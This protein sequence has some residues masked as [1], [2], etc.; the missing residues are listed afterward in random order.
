MK[1]LQ[2][3]TQ[4][5]VGGAQ[6]VVIELTN[7]LIKDGHEI[8]V[9]SKPH[10]P[11][12]DSLQSAVKKITCTDFS[13]NVSI[14]KDLKSF[15]FIRKIIKQESP[16]IIHLHTSKVG[17]LGRL[18]SWP[19][20]TQKTFY[21]MH[22]FDQIRVA[23][24]KFLPLEILAKYLCKK[25]IAVSAYD[26]QN[27]KMYG[28]TNTKLIQN[29]I[30]D[31]KKEYQDKK[32]VDKIISFSAKKSI[33]LSV[34]R[35]AK[36]KRFDLF[37]EVA[38][39]LP[40]YSFVWIGN[41]E[42]KELPLSNIL[43]LGEIPNASAYIS[44]ADIFLLL[45]DHE[46]LPLS[47]IEALSCSTPII[48]SNVGGIPEILQPNFSHITEN[49]S[50]CIKNTIVKMLTNKGSLTLMKKNARI[51]YEKKYTIELMKNRYLEL[52]GKP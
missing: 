41:K 4:S 48:A 33:I 37:V 5:V 7:A 49:T 52:F 19:R 22:G 32:I 21:T 46:G 24:R 14:I 9:L 26:L 8:A 1:I 15:F 43:C 3:I 29:G 10:G 17:L 6:S 42:E 39:L 36:P 45:S 11:M 30:S 35:E 47:I 27:L 18:A 44:L 16:D 28:I 31:K 25:I 20:Y 38:R 40:Q 23:N 12:W 2:V 51:E 34:S 13:R 50:E